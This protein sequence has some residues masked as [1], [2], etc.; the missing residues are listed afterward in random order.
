M[1]SGIKILPENFNAIFQLGNIYLMEKNY[2][3]ALEEYNN[4]IKI[5][6]DFWQAINNKGL[7]YYELNNINL[8]TISFKK[9]LSFE[10]NAE[11]MLGL[12]S[13]LRTKDINKAIVLAKKAL[14]KEPKYV[15]YNY[16]KEQLWGEKIQSSTEELFSN[17]QLE[18]EIL[19][20]K[21]KIN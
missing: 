3:K 9:A 20:A 1:Q 18:N 6:K 11:P 8:A 12:A 21:R 13:C 15:D 7:A 4:A 19:L 14:V 5:K 10:E 2:E 17:N 16:R